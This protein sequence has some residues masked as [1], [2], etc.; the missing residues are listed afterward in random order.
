MRG[1]GLTLVE[2]APLGALWSTL[3]QM[4]CLELDRS[5]LGRAVIPLVNLGA[6]AL[7]R[8]AR[9]ELVMNWLVH[10]RRP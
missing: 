7:D 8:T 9:E 5:R 6:R 4:A 2:L 3:G 10:A 1:A